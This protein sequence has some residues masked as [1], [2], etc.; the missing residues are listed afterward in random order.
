V[1]IPAATEGLTKVAET[2]RGT[3]VF[4]VEGIPEDVVPESFRRRGRT[5]P[6]PRGPFAQWLASTIPHGTCAIVHYQKP[7]PA[8]SKIIRIYK[9]GKAGDVF[10]I[11]S[12]AIKLADRKRLVADGILRAS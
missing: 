1:E 4:L 2:E 8:Q 7:P 3:P 5:Q 12:R 9:V 6:P 10:K 11:T